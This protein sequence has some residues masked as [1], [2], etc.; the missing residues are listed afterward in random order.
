NACPSSAARITSGVPPHVASKRWP[1]LAS[2]SGASSCTTSLTALEATSRTHRPTP[3]QRRRPPP[4]PAPGI[5][6]PR[7]SWQVQPAVT[8]GLLCERRLQEIQELLPGPGRRC[9][10]GHGCRDDAQLLQFL[11]QRP[12]HRDAMFQ[13][14]LA[15]LLNTDLDH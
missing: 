11:R 1:V 5:A 3:T 6:T 2:N 8:D 13:A 14:Q 10:R 7:A 12:H 4:W 15:E 9:L